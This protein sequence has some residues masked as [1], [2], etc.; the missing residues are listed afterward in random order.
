[1]GSDTRRNCH[2]GKEAILPGFV[3]LIGAGV[4]LLIIGSILKRW[5]P[6]EKSGKT[7]V[8]SLEDL[9]GILLLADPDDSQVVL[10][11]SFRQSG[12]DE[13]YDEFGTKEDALKAITD[14]FR[15]FKE[16]TVRIW[17]NTPSC[18]DIRRPYGSHKGTREG[19][20]IW[21]FSITLERP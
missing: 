17:K 12:A 19:R 8:V 5:V 20:K 9:P 14:R 10:M 13:K 6:D 15:R 2:T 4:I 11:R 18:A 21:G 7:G 16:P 3:Y 1:M